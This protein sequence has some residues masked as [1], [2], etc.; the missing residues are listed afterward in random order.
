MVCPRF[1]RD[2]FLWFCVFVAGLTVALVFVL[3][4]YFP[5]THPTYSTSYAV[6]F[7]NRVATLSVLGLSLA[8]LAGVY[9]CRRPSDLSGE[10]SSRIARS[11]LWLA[12]AISALYTTVFS[13]LML[14]SGSSTADVDYFMIPLAEVAYEHGRVYRVAEF[15]YGPLMFD[16]PAFLQRAV[17]PFGVR[18]VVGYLVAN[19]VAQITGL[20]ITF[21]IVQRLPLRRPYRLIA[22]AIFLFAS[23]RPALGMNYTMLRFGTA[24]ALLLWMTGIES[25]WVQTVLSAGAQAVAFAI[26][27]EVGISFMAGTWAYAGV[28]ALREGRR[29]AVLALGALAGG[30]AFFAAVD[31]GYVYVISHFATGMLNQV[32]APVPNILILLAATVFVAPFAVANLLR[33]PADEAA[34]G[35]GFYAAALAMLPAALG[36][37]D[38]LH[39]FFNGAGMYLLSLVAASQGEGSWS[40][41][42]SR[43]WAAALFVFTVL[44]PFMDSAG[45]ARQEGATV[46][47]PD[48]GVQVLED[49]LGHLPA[50]QTVYAPAGAPNSLRDVL[51]ATHHWAPSFFSGVNNAFD[52][53]GDQ[54]KT[55]EMQKA[56]YV[57]IPGERLPDCS[58][59]DRRRVR[60]LRFGY[61][62]R[63]RRQPYQPL[64]LVR[65][66]LQSGFVPEASYK[67]YGIPVLLYR[68]LGTPSNGSS[69]ND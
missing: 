17:A 55:G 12:W 56:T 19:A 68:R 42:P 25:L 64:T 52:V 54:R 45:V 57:L 10:D 37:C 11:W 5:P 3:P 29:F 65:R 49:R 31:R 27:P 50:G 53:A 40:R 1:L 38:D 34:V 59:D 18:P 35:A 47:R 13:W 44:P 4:L 36:L 41:V 39:T 23:L 32:I 69:G 21:Y 26:S 60:L 46:Y 62:Y 22:L 2:H 48:P 66:A 8:V 30:V 16:L 24:F 58:V 7:S 63:N 6:G 51:M 33:R 9:V 61:T 43:I 15:A 67:V 28:R 14:R 20:A